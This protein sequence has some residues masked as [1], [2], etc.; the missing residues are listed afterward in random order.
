MQASSPSCCRCW[1]RSSPGSTSSRRDMVKPARPKPGNPDVVH[2]AVPARPRKRPRQSRSIVL[3]DALKKTGSE[4][5]E[6]EGRGALTVQNLSDRSGVAVS[7]IYEY[8]PAI[9]SLIA[10]VFDDYRTEARRELVRHVESLPPATTLFDGILSMLQFGNAVLQGLARIDPAFHVKST[11]YAE[12]VRL[13]LVKSEHFWS[14]IAMPA[15]M[16]RFSDEVVVKDR[17]KAAF[18]GYQMLVAI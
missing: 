6:K 2:I 16:S 15:L 12:L 10:A 3:V 9:E 4:I 7:S 5:L 17:E 1:W 18:L 8:F 11:Y 13:D 14:A